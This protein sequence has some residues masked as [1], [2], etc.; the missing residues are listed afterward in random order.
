MSGRTRLARDANLTF[1]RK[2]PYQDLN[3]NQGLHFVPQ[4]PAFKRE[5]GEIRYGETFQEQKELKLF[6]LVFEIFG[7][8]CNVCCEQF[9][10]ISLREIQ[11]GILLDSR[12]PDSSSAV[13]K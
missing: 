4:C 10:T 7:E 2:C 8:H 3:L 13:V 11:L 12:N 1:I 6:V 9:L 5:V